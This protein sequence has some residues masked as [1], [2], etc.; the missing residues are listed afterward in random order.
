M[1]YALD[2]TE[3]LVAIIGVIFAYLAWRDL[4]NRK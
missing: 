2:L 3:I 1:E 4:K